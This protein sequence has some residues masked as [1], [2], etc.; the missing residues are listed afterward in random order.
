MT[1]N[2]WEDLTP[3]SSADALNARR[4]DAEMPWS[5]FWARG[6]DRR[7]L[8][9]LHHVAASSPNARLPH[10]KGIEIT[11]SGGKADGSRILA[12]RLLDS[13]QRDIFYRLCLD[14]IAAA[15]DAET[16]AEAVAAALARTWRW[17]HLLRGG[18]DGRLS[19]EEQKGLVGELLVMER[20]LL[21]RLPAHDAVWAWRGPLGAPKDFE[22]GRTCIEA[23]AR[24]GAATPYITISSEHQLDIG[25]IDILFLH[26]AELDR[27]PSDATA[28][29]NLT[30]IARRIH[31]SVG[32][33]DHM[34]ADLFE[35]LLFAAGF[36]WEHNYSDMP[37]VQGPNHLYRVGNGFPSVTP[38]SYPAGVLSVRYSVSLLECERFR[39]PDDVV[40]SALA[41]VANG[42]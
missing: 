17:H 20:L 10:L 6:I 16:E 15:T 1:D 19:A 33:T 31:F 26:V 27:A 40:V 24:R 13:A 30:D 14:I 41:G 37:W 11:L 38:A 12:L 21:P 32:V 22:I 18:G 25:G 2:P 9:L 42:D 35:T 34:A 36:N 29:F 7:C 8:L 3:P 5:F 39:V 28:T 23:K 4:V